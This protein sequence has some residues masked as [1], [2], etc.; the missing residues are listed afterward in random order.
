MVLRTG[1]HSR[2]TVY[3]AW[4]R[5]WYRIAPYSDFELPE[6]HCCTTSEDAS[7]DGLVETQEAVRAKGIRKLTGVRDGRGSV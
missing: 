7:D 2:R 3:R 1:M 4:F 6:L 5:G